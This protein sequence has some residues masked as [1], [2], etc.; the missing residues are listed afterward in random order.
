MKDFNPRTP[1]GVRRNGA[2]WQAASSAFQSTHPLR[3]ATLICLMILP[4]NRFQ[5]THPLRGATRWHRRLPVMLDFNPRTPCGVRQPF[6]FFFR[7]A[8][9]ISIHAPLA[10]CDGQERPAGRWCKHFNPRTPCGVRPLLGLSMRL[11]YPISIH[12]PLAGCDIGGGYERLRQLAISIHAP[13]AGCDN[14]DD[15]FTLMPN[16]ISIHAPLAGCDVCV[17]VCVCVCISIH[18]P[19][20]GC[21]PS[22]SRVDSILLRF[23]ST[24]PLRGA[25]DVAKP[26]KLH[27]IISIHAPLAGCDAITSV[28]T[29]SKKSRFQS[30]HPLRGATCFKHADKDG[31]R[32]SIHAPLAGCDGIRDNCS[33]RSWYFNPRTPC[34]VRQQKRTKKCG[35]FAQKV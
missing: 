2:K 3:G 18:A 9:A 19:L 27:P 17:C 30:T 29:G 28:E 25:T 22:P 26:S 5:S 10:G 15:A 4:K 23:Q 32:I 20:A 12:A 13:L 33:Q 21:D 34:G 6:H 7:S 11:M 14:K 16:I 24:H 35:T 31:K 8:I 1:C